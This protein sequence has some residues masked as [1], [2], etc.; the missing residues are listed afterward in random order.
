MNMLRRWADRRRIRALRRSWEA[1]RVSLAL[2]L[3]TASQDDEDAPESAAIASPRDNRFLATKA[4]TARRMPALSAVVG[5]RALEQEA[6]AA[7]RDMTELMNR[8]PTLADA[9]QKSLLE[10]DEILR[11]WHILYL[12]L[13]KLEGAMTGSATDGAALSTPAE[14][15]QR[16]LTPQ[17]GGRSR[18]AKVAVLAVEVAIVIG[19]L[20]LVASFLG[21]GADDLRG[22][23][24]G[25]SGVEGAAVAQAPTGET[26]VTAPAAPASSSASSS[27]SFRMPRLVQ[28]VI[29]RYG[30]L[31]TFVLCGAV[32]CGLLL[33]FGLRSR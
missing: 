24:S 20:L 17:P 26:E 6:A 23:L 19:F 22:V 1:F 30:T 28:P 16:Q 31:G 33:M 12:F 13:A 14:W 21:I 18:L 25:R 10:R 8:V 32:A 5:R 15:T 7:A 11:E 29:M 9:R 27:S 2:E 4:A 3:A